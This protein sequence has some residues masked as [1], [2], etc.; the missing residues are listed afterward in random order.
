[1]SNDLVTVFGGTGFLGCRLVTRLID[2]GHRVRLV[3]RHPER[4]RLAPEREPLLSRLAADISDEDQVA[5]AVAESTAV[6]N[7]VSLYEERGGL[8]FDGIHVIAAERLARAA[9]QAGVPRLVHV[10]GVGADI[11]SP[12][13]YVR[14]RAH[15]ENAVRTAFPEAVLVRPSV[16]FGRQDALVS[17]LVALTRLPVAP[18]FGRGNTRLQPVWVDDL[19]RAMAVLATEKADPEPLYEFGGHG[20]YRYRD[21]LEMVRTYLGRS[22]LSLP[23]PFPI[24]RALSGVLHRL[25]GSTPLTRDQVRLMGRDNV[26]GDEVA[27]FADLALEPLSFQSALPLCIPS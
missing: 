26:V 13:S 24:W 5:Q 12:S 4:L 22:G 2:N 8:T 6:V 18:M 14:A 27:T 25:P 17:A 15:G 9:H 1:M 21:M 16:L 10:S 11:H 3:A 23:V 20:V 19:A 7:A